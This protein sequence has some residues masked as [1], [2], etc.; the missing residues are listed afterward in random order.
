[1]TIH[2]KQSGTI[3]AVDGMHVKQGGTIKE[4]QS[5]YVKEGGV[6]KQ[7]FDLESIVM[8]GSDDIGQTQL[9]LTF[10]TD[11]TIYKDTTTGAGG[12][13]LV[14]NWCS[15]LP[16]TKSYEIRLV[17]AV[18]GDAPDLGV[19]ATA[20]I[21]TDLSGTA[22]AFSAE[23]YLGV[24]DQGTPHKIDCTVEIRKAGDAASAVQRVF[25]ISASSL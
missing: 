8:L 20:D 16:P 13:S 11:G 17:S 18:Y 19:D 24:L 7:W 12:V 22:A 9:K 25:G 2:V 23:K 1:M 3:K 4:V 5:A 21:F 15:N 10:R 6:I 14:E